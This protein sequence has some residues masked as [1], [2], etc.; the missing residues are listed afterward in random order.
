[1]QQPFAQTLRFTRDDGQPFPDWEEKALS[2]VAP[3]QR[4]FD[5]PNEKIEPGSVPIVYSNGILK[6]HNEAR[7]NG[8]GVVTG[9]S[10]TI[11][12]VHYIEEAFWPHNTSLWV[13][14][15]YSPSLGQDLA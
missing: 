11:G 8:P 6:H 15:S 14:L 12:K 9:R 10:G 13:A 5:L 3:L 7:T 4:G 2:D 1:M